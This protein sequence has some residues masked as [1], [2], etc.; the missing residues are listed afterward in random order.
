MSATARGGDY[1]EHGAYY[2]D[3]RVARAIVRR[4]PFEPGQIVL[5]GHAG[6][7][8]FL[9]ELITRSRE[10]DLDLQ[11]LAMDVDDRAPALAIGSPRYRQA[12]QSFLDRPVDW[13][14][15]KTGITHR[16]Q[17]ADPYPED[18]PAPDWV[19]GNPPF[20]VKL[21]NRIRKSP[22]GVAEAHCWRALEL[23]RR[24]VVFILRTGFLN[25]STRRDPGGLLFEH[26]PRGVWLLT[27]RPSF[28]RVGNDMASYC[29]VWWDREWSPPDPA[30]PFRYGLDWLRWKDNHGRVPRGD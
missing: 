19:I 17:T 8:V 30:S 16:I 15:A 7:G 23:T 10:D 21:P 29:V 28:T 14:S 3:R 18:W 20:G 22:V 4:L 27:P 6:S 1:A 24:H 26:P 12:C 2:T 11:L 9:E 13:T 5:E 25:A